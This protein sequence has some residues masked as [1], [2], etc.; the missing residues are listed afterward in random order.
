MTATNEPSRR[1]FLTTSTRVAAAA[2]L[3]GTG[4][5][6]TSGGGK[7]EA[8]AGPKPVRF[9]E[10]A[11]IRLGLIG[12]G[13]RCGNLVNASAKAKSNVEIKAIADPS[14]VN[15]KQMLGI[16]EKHW[17]NKPDVYSGEQDYNAKLLARD[18]IDAV[19]VATPC[20]WHAE[21]YLACFA[22]GKHFYGEK[23]MCIELDE[24]NA[25]CAAQEKNPEVLCQIGFQRRASAGYQAGV[26]ALHEGKCGDLFEAIGG[27]RI[28][29]GPLG[30]PDQGTKVW[31]GRRKMSG[32]WMLEQACHTWDVFCWVAGEMPVA[33]T[34]RG[35]RG[36]FKHID[37]E[38]DVTDFYVAHLEFPSGLIADFE[39]NWMCPKH[40]NK[41][42]FN[43]IFER[44][45]G[46]KGGVAFST[47]KNEAEFYPRDGNEKV[48]KFAEQVPEPTQE[49]I[50]SFYNALRTNTRPVST[51]ENGRMA[52]LTGM[53]V[54]KAV[55]ERRRVT[56][57]EMLKSAPVKL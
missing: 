6:A 50:V 16:I 51:V 31:F 11:T 13:G 32:D 44:F 8:V 25:I 36:L 22:A 27:W 26:K 17:G 34:G 12:V 28:S 39:H 18:D 38:R 56:M 41:L 7:L 43:G 4:G 21:M 40:D 19:L 49:S 48:E 30:L 29:G 2:G 1:Q 20:N 24:V 14:D 45:T 42:L 9:K 15:V 54:R 47:W 55:Y 46:P 3:I 53:L 35:R 37:P 5:C 23:P 33:A 52:T 57:E 10:G